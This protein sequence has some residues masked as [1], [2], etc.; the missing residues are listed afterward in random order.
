MKKILVL[1]VICLSVASAWA[2][3]E[4]VE[5]YVTDSSGEVYKNSYGECWRD[6]FVST[7]EKKVECGYP[8]PKVVTINKVCNSTIVF[9]NLQF[10]FDSSVVSEA[11]K[12]MLAKARDAVLNVGR[13][14]EVLKIV[15]IGHTDSTGPAEYNEALSLRRAE[16]VITFLVEA[17]V[18][19]PMTASGMGESTPIADNSTREGRA[20]NRRVEIEFTEI[21]SAE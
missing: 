5:G 15:V 17:G 11:D 14:C 8:A 13:E 20:E 16:A 2:S 3:D 10:A 12:E 1:A 19:M 9:K 7:T 21:G 18:T 4:M 6:R